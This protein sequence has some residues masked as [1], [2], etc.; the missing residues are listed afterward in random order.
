MIAL[1]GEKFVTA[2]KTEA[3]LAPWITEFGHVDH[4]G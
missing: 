1:M 2:T 4:G 3:T